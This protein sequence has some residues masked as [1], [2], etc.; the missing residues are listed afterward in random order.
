[1]AGEAWIRGK[2]FAF[3]VNRLEEYDALLER[4]QELHM[5]DNQVELARRYAYHFFFRRMIPLSFMESPERFH[6]KVALDSLDQLAEG[7]ES[8]LD[9]ICRG[10]LKGSAFVYP[11]ELSMDK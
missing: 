7:R 1:V 3:D 6:L 10:I 4:I 5:T 2:G 8:G 11:A 9:I